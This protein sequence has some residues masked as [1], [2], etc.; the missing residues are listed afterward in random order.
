MDYTERLRALRTDSDMSQA[1]IAAAIGID[2]K[3]YSRYE[4][5]TNELPLRYL[6]KLCQVYGVSADY[7]LGLPKGLSWPR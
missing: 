5:G 4:T 6:M 3:Q 1:A 2:Q 7:L